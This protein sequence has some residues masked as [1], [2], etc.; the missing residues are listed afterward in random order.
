MRFLTRGLADSE[1]PEES[2]LLGKPTMQVGHGGEKR[3]EY[4]GRRYKQIRRWLEDYAAV[5]NE[6][7]IDE[8]DIPEF[9]NMVY[10]DSDIWLEIESTPEAWAEKL[11]AIL[12]F[13]YN[14]AIGTYEDVPNRRSG[15]T[16]FR[17]VQPMAANTHVLHAKKYTTGASLGDTAE[18][19]KRSL[20]TPVFL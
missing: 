13:R 5:M 14:E 4:G 20:P 1:Y 9:S 2:F 10:I 15:W 3:M 16:S 12:V 17:R 6:D 8:G 18:I 11:V 19:A 7:Y